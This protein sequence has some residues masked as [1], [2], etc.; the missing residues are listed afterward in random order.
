[1][2]KVG[3][4]R[5]AGRQRS[6]TTSAIHRRI[7]VAN[8]DARLVRR[9]AELLRGFGYHVITAARGRDIIPLAAMHRSELTVLETEFSGHERP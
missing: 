9:V 6:L 4:T 3:S 7:L 1:M 8:P 5:H 2:G